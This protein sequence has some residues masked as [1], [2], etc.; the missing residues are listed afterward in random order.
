MRTVAIVEQGGYLRVKSNSFFLEKDGG[1]IK[2]FHPDT[3]SEFLIIGKV[4]VSSSAI[5]LAM[6][7]GINFVFLTLGGKF[8][9]KI[10][11]RERYSPF[12]RISQ[13]NS[14]L[15]KRGHFAKIF[16]YGKIK[17]QTFVIENLLREYIR[18]LAG[19]EEEKGK[20]DVSF[21]W[22]EG[23]KNTSDFLL[24]RLSELENVQDIMG[25]EG[26]ASSLYFSL[27]P[28]FIF[29]DDFKFSGR[30][31]RPPKDRF[32]SILSSA[33]TLLLTTVDGAV[34]SSGFDPSI[35]FLHEISERRPSLVLDLMEEFRP[36]VDI[37]VINLVNSG[38]F[39][40]DDFFNPSEREIAILEMR[41]L[42]SDFDAKSFDI[43]EVFYLKPSAWRSL[44]KRYFGFL[45]TKWNYKGKNFSLRDIIY[46]QVYLLKRSLLGLD[47]YSPFMPSN[48]PSNF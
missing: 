17:N 9:G 28:R 46:Q 27:L 10:I 35:G 2:T 31:K 34:M 1:K 43:E 45:Q 40:K 6:R 15:V 48:L 44:V 12:L 23:F 4:E 38:T 39:S 5:E 47:N 32:N 36:L 24:F 14:Y 41:N 26:R 30:T 7:K 11:S 16:V 37:F 20:R 29:C 21:E 25:I 13:Y 33:Y 22:A 8:V 42:F 19:S 3:V 18:G